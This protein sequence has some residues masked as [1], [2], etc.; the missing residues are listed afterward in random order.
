MSGRLA[1]D[2][3]LTENEGDHEIQRVVFMGKV[4]YLTSPLRTNLVFIGLI[5]AV[6]L[7][8]AFSS[9]QA[10]MM[11]T[12][13]TANT[14]TLAWDAPGDD[15]PNGTAAYY[16]F[17]YSTS[18]IT[19]ANW[20]LAERIENEPTPLP[21]GAAQSLVVG[22][23]VPNTTYY[24]AAKSA[25]EV[26]NWSGL[27]GVIMRSTLVSGGDV[28]PPAAIGDL[29]VAAAGV[30]TTTTT[31]TGPVPSLRPPKER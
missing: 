10:S 7:P 4:H 26:P 6:L 30:P 19:E 31:T 27:S 15:G 22:G 8:G 17:R 3:P 24:F 29:Q 11:A 12:E 14:V 23:L 5:S 20:N 25:D 13:S 28:T 18:L 21:A 2:L 9:V 16:D 1:Q